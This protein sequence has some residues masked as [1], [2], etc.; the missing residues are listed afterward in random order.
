MLSRAGDSIRADAKKGEKHKTV[1]HINFR[2]N[3]PDE[4]MPTEE[5]ENL[6]KLNILDFL[7]K[8]SIISS[9]S[10]ARRLIEQG[11]IVINNEK[12]QDI[13]QILD[14]NST[15]EFIVKKGKKTFLKVVIK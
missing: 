12:K 1:V 2:N 14:L 13:V 3:I 6:D 8:L 4:Y 10:E 9:K 5:I 15:K 11:G 7:A